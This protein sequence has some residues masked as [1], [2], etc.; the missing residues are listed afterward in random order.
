MLE[1]GAYADIASRGGVVVLLDQIIDPHNAGA[2]MRSA[3]A[4]GADGII[5]PSAHQA[6]VTPV[7]VKSSAGA[8]AH[9]PVGIVSNL[10]QEI[11]ILKEAGFWIAGSS[12]NG[13]HKA[14][15]LRDIRPLGIVIGSEG[16]GMRR[17]TEKKCDYVCSIP[18]RGHISSLNASVAAGILLYSALCTA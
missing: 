3:E 11:G 15:L 4:L 2:I 10:A 5:I 6:P 14:S 12:Q 1:K 7:T 18:L 16:E 13:Q 17:L 9:L 8:S